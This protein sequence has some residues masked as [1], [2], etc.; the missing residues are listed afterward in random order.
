MIES[1]LDRRIDVAHS[2]M[3]RLDA[4][5]RLSEVLPL[6][7]V[8][9]GL[10]DD[11]QM[12]LI[13]D[14]LTAGVGNLPSGWVGHDAES[15]LG[16]TTKIFDLLHVPDVSS[17]TVDSA[18]NAFQTKRPPDRDHLISIS[19]F[20]MERLKEPLEM[21][22]G[23]SEELF[24]RILRQSAYHNEAQSAL[25]RIRAFI[26]DYAGQVWQEASR[27]K[28]RIDLLG[29]DYRI[30][31]DSLD[32]LDTEFG[33][34]LSAALDRLASTN[35]SNW[36][37]SALGC[38]N[39]LLKLGRHLWLAPDEEYESSLLGMTLTLK[40][41]REKNKLS[42]YIDRHWQASSDPEKTLLQE[43]HDL[44]TPIYDRGSKG[45]SDQISH[46]EAE[47]LVR[48]TFRLVDLLRQT[49]GMAPIC[50]S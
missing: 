45:K 6:A 28:D 3:Q 25:Y 10:N 21:L 40:G 17:I 18:L 48:D 36:K 39:V 7:R 43:A 20:E 15:R 33:S 47:K 16:A 44:V 31:L 1:G 34:D 2:V 26:Y 27:E 24:N 35:P 14:A 13:I 8:L 5:Q 23:M 49:T 30:V 42:A 29:P 11:D 41:D 22:P 37:L 4:S 38:R 46:A 19:V 32:A 12:S 50:A 9:A